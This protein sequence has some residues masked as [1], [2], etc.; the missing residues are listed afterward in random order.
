VTA[1][2]DIKT[3]NISGAE[4]EYRLIAGPDPD[5]AVLVFLHEGLGCAALWRDFPDQLCVASGCGGLVF[6]RLGYG[7]SSPCDL[8]RPIDYMQ[9]EAKIALPAIL[10]HFSIDRLILVGH[11]DGASIALVYAGLLKE[12][13]P[14]A[15]IAMAPHVFCEDISIAGI[16]AAKQVYEQG[17]LKEKLAKFH[18]MNTECAFRGWNDAWLDPAFQDWNIENY[19][20]AVLAPVLAIQGLD[21][22]YGTLAQIDAIEQGVGGSFQKQ[23]L[24]NCGHTPWSAQ[25]EDV[26]RRSVE[27]IQHISR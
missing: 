4:I 15:V 20:P 7:G 13:S 6:S 10:Q 14:D 21:D 24:E 17:V 2:T 11:S 12:P 18:G 19:L 23:L 5:A 22:T 8:P 1:P 26:A 27:F 25:R 9:R 16:E 3:A